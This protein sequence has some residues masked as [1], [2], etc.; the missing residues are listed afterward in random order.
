MSRRTRI[1]VTWPRLAALTFGLVVV[2]ASAGFAA[3]E[4]DEDTAS[5]ACP[6]ILRAA[7]R[8]V[9]LQ[10]GLCRQ[11]TAPTAAAAS[12]RPPGQLETM[13]AFGYRFAE[14]DQASF[15]LEAELAADEPRG[16]PVAPEA[17]RDRRRARYVSQATAACS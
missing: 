9:S 8:G 17:Y 4:S 16:T 2:P 14:R 7:R 5:T 15:R 11:S 6:V 13:V 1:Q 10:E 3:H 12:F